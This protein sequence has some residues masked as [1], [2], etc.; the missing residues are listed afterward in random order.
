MPRFDFETTVSVKLLHPDCGDA[1]FSAILERDPRFLRWNRMSLIGSDDDYRR[2]LPIRTRQL[3]WELYDNP[4]WL[5]EGGSQPEHRTFGTAI[6]A[7]SGRASGTSLAR[8]GIQKFA[9]LS[10]ERHV[11]TLTISD[12]KLSAAY[13]FLQRPPTWYA[14]P[15]RLTDSLSVRGEWRN[16]P[17]LGLKLRLFTNG[18]RRKDFRISQEVEL[19]E[20]P[21]VEVR[22]ITDMPS[23]AFVAAAKDLWFSI[24]VLLMYRFRQSVTPLTEQVSTPDTVTTTWHHLEVEPRQEARDF[25]SIDFFGRVDDFL[26][27]AA[28][29]LATYRDQSGLLHAAA[30]GYAASFGTSVLDAQLTDRVEAIERLVSVYEKTS[31]FDRARVSRDDWKPIKSAL[32]RTV[33]NLDLDEELASHLKRGF[34][35]S[36]T[37]TLQERIE[38]MAARYFGLW[39]QEDQD[40]L[41]GLNNMIAA[42][43]AIVHGRLVDNIERLAVEGLRAQVI[44]EKLFMSFLG[45]DEYS[46]SGYVHLSISS[47]E[48][49]MAEYND[50]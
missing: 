24:R 50:K 16:L 26:A 3:E 21:G 48:R 23:V 41:K 14:Y 19:I 5:K 17:S 10:L 12:G 38:R 13:E 25:D 33:D 29:R 9:D 18:Y 1:V 32:K 49:Q 31:G 30:W 44:F 37:L 20:I 27:Q 11:E 28:S 2:F 43:N 39:N 34:A 46:S 45:C 8:D 15:R 35:S 4:A 42:R 47:M 6:L 22:P 40:L 36:P 7:R